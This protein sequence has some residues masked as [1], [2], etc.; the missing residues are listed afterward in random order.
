MQSARRA[1]AAWGAG[2]F[3]LKPSAVAAA[4]PAT[5]CRRA[6]AHAVAVA[7]LSELERPNMVHMAAKRGVIRRAACV[8]SIG[9]TSAGVGTLPNAKA[10]MRATSTMKV[11]PPPGQT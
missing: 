5:G 4:R 6:A 2:A 1:E 10:G 9:A 3:T 7:P 11:I 8:N